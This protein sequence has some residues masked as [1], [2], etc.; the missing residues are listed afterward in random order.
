MRLVAGHVFIDSE[1][2]REEET[3]GPDRARSTIGTIEWLLTIWTQARCMSCIGA[4]GG[5]SIPTSFSETKRQLT[6]LLG[7]AATRCRVFAAAT[8]TYP[9]CHARN[10]RQY[11]RT[12]APRY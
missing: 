1:F 7:K 3:A 11:D 5:V 6:E 10:A 9:P 12:V 4:G 8:L 2:R